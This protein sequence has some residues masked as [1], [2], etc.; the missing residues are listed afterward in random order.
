MES[1]WLVVQIM[2]FPSCSFDSLLDLFHQKRNVTC[3]PAEDC[4]KSVTITDYVLS[5]DSSLMPQVQVSRVIG[6]SGFRITFD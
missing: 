3:R 4:L 2:H 6:I 5:R 1:A